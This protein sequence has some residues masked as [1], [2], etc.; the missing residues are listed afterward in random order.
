[1]VSNRNPFSAPDGRR[2]RR[3]SARH[4]G[5]RPLIANFISS[6]NFARRIDAFRRGEEAIHAGERA[7][8]AASLRALSGAQ[9]WAL[10]D[11]LFSDPALVVRH[12]EL[13]HHWAASG[14]AGVH[15]LMALLAGE[16]FGRE[17]RTTP[18]LQAAAEAAVRANAELLASG[19]TPESW[20][21]RLAQSSTAIALVER[22]R[23]GFEILR[24]FRLADLDAL[25]LDLEGAPDPAPRCLILEA[26]ARVP[27]AAA[28]AKTYF[29]A[30]GPPA[31]QEALH[32]IRRLQRAASEPDLSVLGFDFDASNREIGFEAAVSLAVAIS[33][34]PLGARCF[35]FESGRALEP[36]LQL[37]RRKSLAAIQQTFERSAR[38]IAGFNEAGQP[39]RTWNRWPRE[40]PRS[41][42]VAQAEQSL[43]TALGLSEAAIGEARAGADLQLASRLI[44]A[45]KVDLRRISPTRLPPLEREILGRRLIARE[46]YEGLYRRGAK[47]PE[48][49]RGE[50]RFQAWDEA[51]VCLE[52]ASRRSRGRVLEP[53]ESSTL[54]LEVHRRLRAEPMMQ[55]RPG[56]LDE[57]DGYLRIIEERLVPAELAAEADHRLIELRPF[58]DGNGRL[59]CLLG[60]FLLA[61]SRIEASLVSH[62]DLPPVGAD[63]RAEVWAE[64][65]RAHLRVVERHW[66]AAVEAQDGPAVTPRA[67]LP[68]RRSTPPPK[69]G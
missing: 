25:E 19:E 57:L 51:R 16:G 45:F 10:R 32:A 23:S 46:V 22:T 33:A 47:Y 13:E 4:G 50:E 14:T 39:I 59:A 60:N 17:P 65:V 34:N 29:D 21:H 43:F 58:S 26:I 20:V 48:H 11:A 24:H 36:L 6:S 62:P 1:V 12:P 69:L 40:L 9:L 64:G 56:A 5:W 3:R 68:R 63:Q 7:A 67:P 38:Q 30:V 55:P 53:G 28:D 31:F 44:R 37:A 35:W 41:A 52:D 54:L 18:Q 49:A 15:K 61:R 27:G 8:I 42:A 66:R 2:A